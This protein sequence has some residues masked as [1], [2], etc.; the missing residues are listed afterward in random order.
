MSNN[1]VKL[2]SK[3]KAVSVV[4]EEPPKLQ[5]LSESF[6]RPE[7]L[8]SKTYKLK[9]PLT[10]AALY[11]TISDVTLNAGTEHET[12]RPFEIF[13]NSKEVSNA[14]WVV[15][16]T[17]LISAVWRKGGDAVFVVEELK[18]IYDPKG[19]YI[20]KD[21]YVPSLVAEIGKIIERHFES[22]GLIEKTSDEILEQ[23][24]KEY[25]KSGGNM[26]NASICPKC[27]SKSFVNMSGCEMCVSCGF[28]KCG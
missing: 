23:K 22:I 20:S 6:K 13:I 17:R 19:G 3:I 18:S 5:E 2:K 28:S 9:S 27:H 24:K 8:D 15:A 4:K 10:E 7:V 16:V 26:D 12:R 21:G 25:L 1:P 14:Q 11:V